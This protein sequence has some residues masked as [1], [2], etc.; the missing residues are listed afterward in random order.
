[1]TAPLVE[2]ISVSKNYG[3]LRPLRVERLAI[4]AGEQ[5]AIIGP[6]QPSA[7]V[8]IGLITGASLPD[9][10]DVR[11]FGRATAEVT[12]SDEWLASLDRFGIVSDRA[13]LLEAFTVLQ[14]LAVP[15]SLEIEPPPED[16]QRQAA[17]LG[18]ELLL[19]AGIHSARAGD[20]DRASRLRLRVA[21][22]LAFNPSLVL[23]EHPSASLPPHDAAATARAIRAVLERRGA[24]SLTITAD[25]AFAS[26][27]ASRVLLL[28]PSTGRLKS[29]LSR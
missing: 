18:A 4:A 8:L 3:A 12:D 23:L 6:D 20:L 13:A 5:V 27:I 29:T 16:I 21:R 24:A 19:D 14:N 7:E 17:A 25:R 10:G 22:A 11:V 2:L 28:E 9:A 26:A 1:V 15:F